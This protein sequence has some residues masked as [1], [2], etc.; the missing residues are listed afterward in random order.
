MCVCVGRVDSIGGLLVVLIYLLLFIRISLVESLR[1]PSVSRW[2]EEQLKY[3][4]DIS[5]IFN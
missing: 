4:N 2:G 3:N 1:R 5:L